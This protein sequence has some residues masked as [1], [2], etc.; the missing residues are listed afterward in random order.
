MTPRLPDL[1]HT[2]LAPFLAPREAGK[3]W[4]QLA[5]EIR[6]TQ[7]ARTQ[8]REARRQDRR[9][10][11]EARRAVAR[12][13]ARRLL[14]ALFGSF[15]VNGAVL[16]TA[17]ADEVA[18]A[19]ILIDPADVNVLAYGV[20]RSL[21]DVWS[22]VNQEHRIDDLIT[23]AHSENRDDFRQFRNMYTAP[24]SRG[25][26]GLNHVY[27]ALLVSAREI[28]AIVDDVEQGN[29]RGQLFAPDLS[30]FRALPDPR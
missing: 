17:P 27:R 5:P 13:V 9:N 20:E 19:E 11:R 3:V 29:W 16:S 26:R 14:L 7:H 30:E 6:G 18:E 23:D 25:A 28:D 8:L 4:G 22:H 12:T 15:G 2:N 1:S 21:D 24:D 10:R